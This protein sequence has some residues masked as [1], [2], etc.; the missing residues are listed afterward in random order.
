VHCHRNRNH[1]A[2]L[3]SNAAL[4]EVLDGTV[5]VNPMMFRL[6][7]NRSGGGRVFWVCERA[8]RN[9]DHRRQD[10]GS[11][12]DRRPAVGAKIAMDLPAAC[13]IARELFRSSGN[14]DG[15]DGIKGADAKWRAGPALAVKTM[16]G[17][18]QFCWL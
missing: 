13:P 5:D 17:G 15:V 11:P 9:A 6:L 10:V 16:T 7:E 14:R 12:I 1:S 18:N 8:D 3:F 2:W 4:L